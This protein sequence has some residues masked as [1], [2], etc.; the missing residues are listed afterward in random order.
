MKKPVLL[1]DSLVGYGGAT[2]VVIEI[3][4]RINIDIIAG[5]VDYSWLKQFPIK[6]NVKSL[7]HITS[8]KQRSLSYFF[9]LPLRFLYTAEIQQLKKEYNQFLYIG[10]FSFLSAQRNEDNV[11]FC[12]S[13]NRIL[14]DLKEWKLTHSSFNRRLIFNL[15]NTFLHTPDKRI[16]KENIQTILTQSHIVNQRIQTYYG[17]TAEVLFSPIDISKYTY[18]KIGEYYLA[19]SR[20][21]PEKRMDLIA[22]AFLHTPNTLLLVGNGPEKKHIE[23]IIK[24]AKNITLKTTVDNS[25]LI[26]LY[27]NCKAVIYMPK[28]EDYGL[29]PLEAMASGKICIAA[30]EGGCK[31]TILP[32][33]TG[34]LIHPDEASI[35]KTTQRLT[36]TK[37]QT[38]KKFCLANAKN[39]DITVFLNKLSEYIFLDKA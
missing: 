5:I 32:N 18:T 1:C 6:G 36:Q 11:W 31:E 16:A 29:V 30:D 12:F 15:H 10:T 39:Y 38:M 14:Y 23:T 24:G 21:M 25:E 2:S 4:T 20:L 22:K 33:K 9:E 19:V 37:L 17:R 8:P 28:D 26:S 13:P 27:A 7:S 35:Q 3:A 34:Y